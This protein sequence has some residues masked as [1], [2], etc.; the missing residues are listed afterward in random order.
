V[1]IADV[2]S[3]KIADEIPHVR[4]AYFVACQKIGSRMGDVATA[5]IEGALKNIITV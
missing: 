1:A 5:V 2:E 4:E 3:E